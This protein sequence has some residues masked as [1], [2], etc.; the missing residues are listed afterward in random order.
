MH[1]RSADDSFHSWE[2]CAVKSFSPNGG[3]LFTLR[4]RH[5][6][7]LFSAVFHL[8]FAALDGYDA[9]SPRRAFPLGNGRPCNAYANPSFC[10]S[11][12]FW[13]S[14]VGPARAAAACA[15]GCRFDRNTL[16]GL[17]CAKLRQALVSSN[18]ICE[19]A[20]V[21]E[22][23]VRSTHVRARRARPPPTS[24]ISGRRSRASRPARSSAPWL[25]RCLGRGLAGLRRDAPMRGAPGRLPRT[26]RPPAARRANTTALRVRRVR[27]HKS[28]LSPDACPTRLL[29]LPSAQG[30]YS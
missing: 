4:S 13:V 17:L 14:R 2:C 19:V 22:R 29:R 10:G 30:R 16:F 20:V 11:S 3:L 6:H 1:L 21:A 28:R 7:S 12:S 5:T 26:A 9:A 25:L 18:L 8:L 23:L 27:A 15:H 24:T